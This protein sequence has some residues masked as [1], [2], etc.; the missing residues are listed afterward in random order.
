MFFGATVCVLQDVNKQKF[1]NIYTLL[2]YIHI[3]FF[4]GYVSRYFLCFLLLS[5]SPNSTSDFIIVH[6]TITDS[7]DNL[8]TKHTIKKYPDPFR[9]R[10]KVHYYV[11]NAVSLWFAEIIIFFSKQFSNCRKYCMLSVGDIKNMKYSIHKLLCC[12]HTCWVKLSNKICFRTDVMQCF[13]S[14]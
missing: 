4:K 8:Q 9:K 2:T 3:E 11:K 12:Y 14:A 13:G 10:H 1:I 6:L 7:V 5:I